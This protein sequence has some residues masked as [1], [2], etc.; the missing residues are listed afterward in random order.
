MFLVILPDAGAISTSAE[1]LLLDSRSLKIKE[2][3]PDTGYLPQGEFMNS[4]VNM[5]D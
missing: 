5:T 3:A 1:F 2:C 4:V